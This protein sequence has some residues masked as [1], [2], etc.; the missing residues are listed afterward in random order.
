[1]ICPPLVM[2][3]PHRIPVQMAKPQ[4]KKVRPRPRVCHR[5]TAMNSPC[6]IQFDSDSRRLARIF[7]AKAE[8]EAARIEAKYSR[9][10]PDS[11]LSKINRSNGSPVLVDE[12]TM[13]LLHYADTCHKLSDGLFDVTSGV[14]RRIWR[15]D[16]SGTIPSDAEIEALLPLI[17]WDKVKLG[18]DSV[19]LEP[20]MEIDFGGIGKEYAV[21]RVLLAL[22]ADTKVPLLVNFGGDLRV[23]APLGSGKPW[24]ISIEAAEAGRRSEGM[25]EISSGALT[26]S[27]DARR[28]LLKNGVRYGHILNPQS[29]RPVMGAP[30]SITVAAATCLEAGIMSTLAM[31]KGQGAEQF[32]RDEGLAAWVLR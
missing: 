19:T 14:L 9:Y 31:A 22:A 17:G 4:L 26:T 29:G 21:D 1:M 6:E 16:G 12:E 2:A 23:S 27:G 18:A 25:L 3:G 8:A 30:R 28:Y 15:F 32:L 10:Q 11:L 24:R 13:G 7:G 20:G 5:F